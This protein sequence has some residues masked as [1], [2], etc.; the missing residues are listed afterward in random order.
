MRRWVDNSQV[1]RDEFRMLARMRLMV[2]MILTV[3]LRGE[4]RLDGDG[5]VKKSGVSQ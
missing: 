2:M 4:K 1:K 3:L 5:E